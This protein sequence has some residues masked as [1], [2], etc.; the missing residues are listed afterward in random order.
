[1]HTNDQ[2]EQRKNQYR[3][4]YG[5]KLYNQ[6]TTKKYLRKNILFF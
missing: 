1:M 6:L 4:G 5:E 3:S 2:K